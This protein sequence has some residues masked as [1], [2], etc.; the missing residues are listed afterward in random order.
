MITEHKHSVSS[1]KGKGK[2]S[3]KIE[4]YNMI[5]FLKGIKITGMF[6]SKA[7]L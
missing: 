1:K 5:F 7:G 4:E 2:N 6:K 3:L